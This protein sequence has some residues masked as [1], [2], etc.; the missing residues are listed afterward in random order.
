MPTDRCPVI[1]PGHLQKVNDQ[2]LK[3]ALLTASM[4]DLDGTRQG[5][6]DKRKRDESER[7]L[8]ELKE[9]K[10]VA[11]A[12]KA[13][14][15]E[16]LASLREELQKKCDDERQRGE[17]K[18]ALYASEARKRED[19]FAATHAEAL[20]EERAAAIQREQTQNH[21]HEKTLAGV[22]GGQKAILDNHK[23]T[24]ASRDTLMMDTTE[25][26][27]KATIESAQQHNDA[28]QRMLDNNAEAQQRMLDKNAETQAQLLEKNAVTQAQLLEKNAACLEKM[29]Q[30]H[31]NEAAGY[32]D[33][34]KTA[35]TV[36][37]TCYVPV[38]YVFPK[39]KSGLRSSLEDAQL[40]N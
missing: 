33:I 39:V 30:Y 22:L 3:R 12:E 17:E 37:T 6:G 19:A 27:K 34:V 31:A 32:R 8:S 4:I 11:D 38:V 5:A 13:K 36:G 2:D 28:Q 20:K 1:T 35:L 40:C 14:A 29:N 25:S 15:L 10:R 23:E 7:E 21:Q 9:A 18:L 24:L 26:F 16:T